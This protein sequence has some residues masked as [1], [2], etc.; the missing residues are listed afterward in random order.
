MV[1]DWDKLLDEAESM[2][3]RPEPLRLGMA[4]RPK[5]F[6]CGILSNNWNRVEARE[7]LSSV[8][9]KINHHTTS[10]YQAQLVTLTETFKNEDGLDSL[11]NEVFEEAKVSPHLCFAQDHSAWAIKQSEMAATCTGLGDFPGK[12]K[13]WI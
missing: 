1:K 12:V 6:I 9:N 4:E 7:N 11:I 5:G 13:L 2:F 8:N 3:Y 10:R